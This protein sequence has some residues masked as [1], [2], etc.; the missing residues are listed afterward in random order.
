MTDRERPNAHAV[1][2]GVPKTHV[3]AP[4][5]AVSSALPS[6]DVSAVPRVRILHRRLRLPLQLLAQYVVLSTIQLA[7]SI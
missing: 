1:K 3:A 6:D 5:P 7:G 2:S 4:D